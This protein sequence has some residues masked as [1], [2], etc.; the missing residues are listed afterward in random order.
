MAGLQ[1]AKKSDIYL[2]FQYGGWKAA[3]QLENNK[4]SHNTGYLI[5]M[6]HRNKVQQLHTCFWF[7]LFRFLKTTLLLLFETR[8]TQRRLEW[9][10]EAKV[11]IPLDWKFAGR[12]GEICES[13]FISSAYRA[14]G[15]A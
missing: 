10:T 8:A 5:Y 12:I 1:N 7:D 14:R 6:A 2:F 15:L 11:R 4:K 3:K 9:Q 13:V